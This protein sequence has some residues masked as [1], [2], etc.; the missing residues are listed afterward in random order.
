MPELRQAPVRIDGKW[1]DSAVHVGDRGE[2]SLEGFSGAPFFN[3]GFERL[4]PGSTSEGAAALMSDRS[5]PGAK[6]QSVFVRFA[7]EIQM[8]KN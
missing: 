6:L 7:A 3:V 8:V 1:E 5:R 4:Q 2:L